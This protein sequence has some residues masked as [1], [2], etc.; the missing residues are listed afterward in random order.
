MGDLR[1][2][3]IIEKNLLIQA[4]LESILSELPRLVIIGFYTGDEPNLNVL[5]TKQDPDI[6]FLN[7]QCL[8][9]P[10]AN[11]LNQ[12]KGKINPLIFG[13]LDDNAPES[14]KSPFADRLM[15]SDNK[16]Q[17]QNKIQERCNLNND[18]HDKAQVLSSREITILKHVVLGLTNQEIADKLFLSVHTVMTH[19]KNINK[20][21]GIKTVSGLMVYALMNQLVSMEDLGDKI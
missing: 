2:V 21:L 8:D 6:M 15:F 20:K 13:L 4:G 14:L 19:R 3:V 1:T 9:V 10:A 5:L 11:F 18:P 17:I 12:L 7:P 16:Q